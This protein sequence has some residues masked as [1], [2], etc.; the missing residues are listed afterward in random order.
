MGNE[1]HEF[2]VDGTD[3]GIPQLLVRHLC[4]VAQD[5]QVVDSENLVIT[6]FAEDERLVDGHHV[7]RCMSQVRSRIVGIHSEYGLWLDDVRL[8]QYFRQGKVVVGILGLHHD[9]TVQQKTQL[10]AGLPLLEDG[11]PF[12][13]G[14]KMQL[15][16]LYDGGHVVFA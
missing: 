15:Y 2:F 7:H 13:I 5:V 16:L 9:L 6:Q 12:L 1:V 4:P 14:Q 11:F 10:V 8:F 3:V